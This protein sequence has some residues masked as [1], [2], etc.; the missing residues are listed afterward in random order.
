[1]AE[2]K[3]VV[4]IPVKRVGTDS[5]HIFSLL[6]SPRRSLPSWFRMQIRGSVHSDENVWNA[7]TQG[8]RISLSFN[9][10]NTPILVEWMYEWTTNTITQLD[11]ALHKYASSDH[12]DPFRASL[13]ADTV[14][15]VLASS[16]SDSG[17]TQML[18]DGVT[19]LVGIGIARLSLV[20]TLLGLLES[21]TIFLNPNISLVVGEVFIKYAD[22]YYY[23]NEATWSTPPS[24]VSNQFYE[25]YSLELPP[26]SQVVYTFMKR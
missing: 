24:Q 13:V 9:E 15:V 17:K 16:A 25:M 23:P 4:E 22:V 14:G 7:C 2:D 19:T 6:F 3:V 26:F 21:S 5:L 8:I 1:M 10:I 11:N 20:D 12:T 18:V